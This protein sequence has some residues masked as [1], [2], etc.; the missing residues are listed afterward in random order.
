M[1]A[2][3]PHIGPPA[4]QHSPTSPLE[5]DPLGTASPSD[6][7]CLAPGT[8]DHGNLPD[9]DRYDAVLF[10]WDGTL[11]N[12]HP[13]NFRALSRAC[14]SWGLTLNESFYTSRIGTSGAELISE[15]AATTGTHV[16]IGDVVAQCLDLILDEIAE[17]QTYRPVVQLAKTLHGRLPMAIAS[18]GARR[19]VHA[20]LGATGLRPLF[21]DVI[22]GEDAPRGKPDPGL[23]LLASA[24][25]AVTPARC[26]VYED[27]TEGVQAAE[28]GGMDVVDVRCFRT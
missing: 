3:D 27:S 13:L 10:D 2:R 5:R 8:C 26:L 4:G 16:P 6:A 20:G 24:R 15:L 23:F 7:R 14:A 11:V 21:T 28:A 12:S 18:G 17:L 19:A 25:L 1:Q 22:T 9:L